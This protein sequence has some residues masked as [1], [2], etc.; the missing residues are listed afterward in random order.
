MQIKTIG[1]DLGKTACD[2]VAR[3]GRGKVVA[4]RRLSRAR[5][6]T[7]LATLPPARVGM[8]ASCGAHHLARRLSELGHE[9]RLMPAQYVRPFVQTDKHDQADAEAIAEAVQRPQMGFVPIESAAQ[10]DLQAL[11]RARDRLVTQ[12]TG[13][14]NQIRAFLLERGI[15]LQPG[16]LALAR[17][18]PEML[19]AA[20]ELSPT[21]R[22]RLA[23]LRVHW[24]AL[25]DEIAAL[26]QHILI[27]ART[28]PGARLLMTIPGIGAPDRDRADRGHRRRPGVRP[29]ARPRLLAR[30]GAAA[31]RH[32]RQGAAARHCQTRQRLSPAPPG[33]RRAFAQA[34]RQDP[35]RPPRRL[36]A[37]PGS[38]GPSERRD[39]GARGQARPLVL[40]GAGQEPAVAAGQRLSPRGCS[41]HDQLSARL[42]KG[43]ATTVVRR[44]PSLTN[45]P[46]HR[47]R[48]GDQA[49]D[50]RISLTAR[51]PN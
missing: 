18:L 3:D 41:R 31:A 51:G 4:R 43:M 49:S 21:M 22:A 1:I 5:L 24:Q 17:A 23:R 8:A 33:A 14:I 32:R 20:D 37:R 25:D 34:Q 12:R 15:A 42:R 28:H 46:T 26:D 47:G 6:V 7:W 19:A 44:R 50:A 48:S 40:G 39:R 36:A 16:R 13:L 9:V 30:P 27:I 11:H 29:R 45:E 2:V 35:G 10:L 38:Q